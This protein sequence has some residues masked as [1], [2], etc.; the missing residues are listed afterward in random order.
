MLNLGQITGREAKKH[1]AR[2][3]I[4]RYAGIE[5]EAFP[6]IRPVTLEEGDKVILC[7]DGPYGYDF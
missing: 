2:H 5:R 1:P 4:T 3:T 7:T 6:D